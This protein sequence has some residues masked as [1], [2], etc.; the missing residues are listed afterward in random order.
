MLMSAHDVD[1]YVVM[2]EDAHGSEYVS[3]SDERRAWLTG[4]SGSAGTALVTPTEARLWTDARYFLQAEEQLKGTEW[5]LMKMNTPD[6]P[7]LKEWIFCNLQ[8]K[9]VGVDPVYISSQVADEFQKKWG[10]SISW[11]PLATNLVDALW[12]PTRPADP[13]KSIDVHPIELAGETVQGKLTRVRSSVFEL[14]AEAILMSALDQIAWLFN[15]RGSDI[16]Y[17][18]VFFSYALVTQESAILFVRLLDGKQGGLS[19]AVRRHLADAN[20]DV[21]A[22]A[23]FYSTVNPSIEGKKVFIDPGSCSMALRDLVPETFR[24]SG[25][26]PVEDFKSVKNTSEIEGLRRSSLRD[27]LALCELLAFVEH[28]LTRSP[29]GLEM[30][31]TDELTEVGAADVMTK[32]R[33]KK[34]MYV[35]DSFPTISASG[36]NAALPHYQTSP[37][38]NRKL[39]VDEVYLIDTGGH[40]KDGTTDI[41]RTVHFG[42]ASAEQA[43]LYTRVLQGHINLSRA[44]FPDGAPGLLLDAFAREP[45]WKDGLEY[46][47]GTGHGIGAYMNVHEGPM[48]IGGGNIP[49]PK[50]QSSEGM[51][52]RY[53]APL[54]VGQF[55]S[56]EPG[57][58]KD[59]HFGF[60]I[61][62]DLLVVPCATRYQMGNNKWLAFDCLTLVP[63]CR[64]LIDKAL[65][66]T[67][68]V[69]WLDDYHA[70]VWETLEEFL[71]GPANQSTRKWVYRETRPI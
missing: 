64:A 42:L 14:G 32:I 59:G 53:L 69:K 12:F 35:C 8:R 10:R 13:C 28:E 41:T 45:L 24:V 21:K 26:S 56:N 30:R 4:F 46:G 23:G 50:I 31:P 49:G 47:H 19:D 39:S 57:C 34:D 11:K 63:M 60:R 61:E 33:S 48:G 1:A 15:L 17:N 70:K 22:Y 65:L 7:D 25:S 18:P 6:V 43:R 66:N 52:C 54:R 44:V 37:E 2:S 29:G 3:S 51:K 38:T 55:L 27:S 62:S 71:R 58:Y 16:E 67:E 40:Y 5:T 9:K 20:V 68:Q 36:P